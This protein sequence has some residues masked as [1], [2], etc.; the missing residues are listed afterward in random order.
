MSAYAF[1]IRRA[2]GRGIPY[3]L[4]DYVHCTKFV[5]LDHL[6]GAAKQRWRD[7]DAEL[8]RRLEIDCQFELGGLH[9]R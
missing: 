2:W 1:V 5:S 6:V 4:S 9:N 3:V 8:F 7:V